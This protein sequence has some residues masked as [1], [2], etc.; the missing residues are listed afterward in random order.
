MRV[1]LAEDFAGFRITEPNIH[2]HG[3]LRINKALRESQN[4]AVRRE[5]QRVEPGMPVLIPAFHTKPQLTAI[6]ITDIHE[7]FPSQ[8]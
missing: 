6:R 7:A 3:F 5:R 4:L 1:Q 2:R 8:R